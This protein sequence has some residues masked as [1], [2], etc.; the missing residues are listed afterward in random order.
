MTNLET[1]PHSQDADGA[2]HPETRDLRIRS[3][4]PLLPPAIL[5]DELPLTDAAASTVNRGREEIRRVLDG[6]NDRLIVVA[7]P[8]SIHDADA[9]N[10]YARRLREQAG[11]FADELCVVMRVY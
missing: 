5:T 8:C 9:A 2:G 4:R 11:A 10:D 7:G 3:I 1:P 6:R